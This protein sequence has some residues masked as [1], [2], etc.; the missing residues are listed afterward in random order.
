MASLGLSGNLEAGQAE[1]LLGDWMRRSWQGCESVRFQLPG[2]AREV[3]PGTLVTLPG[4]DGE[5]IVTAVEDGLSRNI[6]ARRIARLAPFADRARLPAA[7]APA[8]ALLGPPL[9]LFLDLPMAADRA[10]EEQFRI[11]VF[12]A[13][14]KSQQVFAA[15]GDSGFALRASVGQPAVT[16]R[17]TAPIGPGFFGRLDRAGE[18]MAQLDFGELASVDVLQMLNGGNV[19]AIRSST[20]AWEIVQFTQAEEVAAMTWRLTDLLRGQ[21]G[22]DDAAAAGAASGADFVLLDDAVV[23]AGLRAG[24]AGLTL[25]WRV[26]P[27]G[28]DFSAQYFAS[29]SET[30]GLRALL[31][32]T[33]VHLRATRRGDGGLDIGW[34]RRSRID[35]DS[36]L[37]PD[38]PLGEATE[39]YRITVAPAGGAIVRDV[40]VAT[41]V[42]TYAAAE[43]AADFAV[44][45]AELDI[46]VRQVSAAVG[47]GLAAKIRVTL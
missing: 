41:S 47:D 27:A 4:L 36:W 14:W 17:L 11:A 20:G 43:L 34:I 15:P 39:S 32:L 10:P 38:I 9:A 28:H 18:I 29:A 6:E 31:P 26:G 13:P 8:A 22:S 5:F 44:P 37:G 40:T 42:C 19:A 3:Q 16:G 12:A 46:A 23:P 7:P 33:P 2:G 25:N 35:A 1:A 45:P 24:E 21:L 30:G